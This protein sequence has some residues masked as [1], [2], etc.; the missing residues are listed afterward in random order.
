MKTHKYAVVG[1]GNIAQAYADT[2]KPYP[3]LQLVGAYDIHPQR[4]KD[5]CAKNGGKVYA[6]LDEVLADPSVEIILNLTIQHAHVEVIRKSL[7]AGKHVHTEKPMAL[8]Y[9][10]A[11]DLVRL[12]DEKGLRFSSSPIVYMG[13]AHQT[14]YKMIR[15]G[16]LGKIS[17]VF[18]EVNWGRIEVW[19]PNPAPFYQVGVLFDVAVYPLTVLTAFLG[20]IKRVHTHGS[21]L[22]PNRKLLNGQ[23]FNLDYPDYVLA[24]IEFANG[25][26]LR[27]TADFF[28]SGQNSDQKSG[29]EFHGDIG[30]LVLSSWHG[31]DSE[32]K[33]G[34]FDKLLEPVKLI[35]EPYKGCEWARA[36]IDLTEAMDAGKPHRAQGAQAAHVV[37]VICAMNSSMRSD[38]AAVEVYSSFT[39]PEPMDWAK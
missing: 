9:A 20:P 29:L 37:E 31:F 26:L 23:T 1:C 24:H 32:V 22:L 25:T 6:S 10:E 14:A 34:L 8:T 15:S 2:I 39:L 11:A 27:L 38:G 12:A 17:V 3:Q 13:E 16:A 35:K 18:A 33:F 21:V 28:V 36:L 7:L 30:S 19:H 5:Y 4:T